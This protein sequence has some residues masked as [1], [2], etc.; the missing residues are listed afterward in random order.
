MHFA[1]PTLFGQ[2][3]IAAA[4]EGIEALDI[5]A[6]VVGDG[7]GNAVVPLETQTNLTN[8]RAT[9]PIQSIIRNPDD[10]T[11]VIIK[12]E[13]DQNTGGWIIREA[14]LVSSD[15]QLLFVSSYPETEK[16][17]L[18]TG[19]DHILTVGLRL[20]ISAAATITL[21]PL[22]GTWATPEQIATSLENWR[23]HLAQPLRPYFIAVDAIASTPP[24]S[25]AVGGTYVIGAAATGLWAGLERRL[26]QYR[27]TGWVYAVAPIGTTV[28]V[29]STGI[30]WRRTATGWR[31]ATA[32]E[33]EHL[34]GAATDLLTTPD[35]VRRMINAKFPANKAGALVND[36]SGNFSWSELLPIK[37]LTKKTSAAN[38]DVLA[39]Y[40]T[41]ADGN[42][43]V[44]V[45]QIAERVSTS[46]RLFGL[47]FFLG[48][49]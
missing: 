6:I 16:G 13:I 42:F 1:V 35:G 30:Y 40:D 26:A 3:A 33:A 24:N 25:P 7:G 38:T 32:S 46:D 45:A 39:A 19:V 28:C 41:V 20:K 4:V 48:S 18:A 37:A 21:K 17:T 11:D 22:E 43:G 14:G 5:Q 27:P 49:K 36:G 2:A 34:A 47:M 23:T 31:T 12:G 44:T 29:S 8:L 10:P 15:G 9:I